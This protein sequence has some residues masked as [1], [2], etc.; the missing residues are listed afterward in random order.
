MNKFN[1]L[2]YPLFLLLSACATTEI[3]P[4]NDATYIIN[5]EFKIIARG[6]FSNISLTKQLVIKNKRDWQQLWNIHNEGQN[7]RRPPVNFDDDIIIA[8]FTGQQPSGGYAVGI[9]K[10]KKLDGNLYVTVTFK[11][12]SPGDAVSLALTQPYIFVSTPKIDGKVS[13]IAD[14]ASTSSD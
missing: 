13:F 14:T 7:T 2:I 4:D 5:I 8:I 12:P 10:M 1:I 6:Q 11:E 3:S 9:S